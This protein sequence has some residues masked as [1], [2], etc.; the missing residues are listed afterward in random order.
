MG[1]RAGLLALPVR[2][3]R[4]ASGVVALVALTG[5][6]PRAAG[7]SRGDAGGAPNDLGP[8]VA[9]A[10]SSPR[11]PAERVRIVVGGD[12]MP[13]APVLADAERLRAAL[14]PLAP[15][16]RAADRA[17]LNFEGGIVPD[18]RPLERAPMVHL[19]RGELLSAFAASGVTALTAA[20]NHAC[21]AG[22]EG[23]GALLAA[24]ERAGVAVVGVD[25]DDVW[26][27]RVVAQRGATTVCALAFTSFVNAREARCS[28][29]PR[30]AV[31]DRGGPRARAR[32]IEL[33]L[34]RASKRCTATIAI[35]HTG[36]EYERQSSH[37][38]ALARAAAE[39]GAA[40][41]V[42]HHPHVPGPVVVHAT[43]DG[44]AVPIF[45]TVGNL[46]SNQGGSWQLSDPPLPPGGKRP[47]A[48]NAW[49]RVG[50][51][52]DLTFAEGEDVGYGAHLTWTEQL[53]TTSLGP[54]ARVRVRLVDPVLDVRLLERLKSQPGPGRAL[55]DDPC[56]LEASGH[57]CVAQPPSRRPRF[58]RS[59]RAGQKGRP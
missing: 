14:A 17:L 31:L 54:D 42:L 33:A 2:L 57:G 24:G 7:G 15:T 52:A 12:V 56:W 21:D 43:R 59:A 41:V 22:D 26:E 5:C 32:K 4:A 19:A 55:L 50:V 25:D 20:N 9:I 29:S 16:F 40:A 28:A 45:T 34:E 18:A 44:R 6:D 27:A 39:A 23:L 49:T 10:A 47:V 37:G 11:G 51:L 36:E 46:L 8:A 48:K 38:L 3:A 35:G 13:H 58:D 53:G 1:P 30:V